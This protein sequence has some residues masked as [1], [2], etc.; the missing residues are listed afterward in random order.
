[1]LLHQSSINSKIIVE[2]HW[3]FPEKKLN[4]L[5]SY[6]LL[7]NDA[8]DIL[9]T[10]R[11]KINI[12][13]IDSGAYSDNT[14]GLKTDIDGYISYCEFCAPHCEFYFN[15]DSDFREDHFSPEN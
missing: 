14:R 10:H 13:I 1:M 11:D 4:I 8:Y 3:R 2:F 6:A 7:E 5:L 9:V 12:R 15:L